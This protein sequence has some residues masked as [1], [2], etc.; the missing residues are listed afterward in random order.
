MPNAGSWRIETSA[1]RNIEWSLISRVSGFG[2]IGT[3]QT[4]EAYS[5]VSIGGSEMF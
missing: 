5:L 2:I 1:P 3:S 4:R